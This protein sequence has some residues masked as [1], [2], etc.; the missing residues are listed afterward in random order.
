M[1]IFEVQSLGRS[2]GPGRVS[3]VAGEWPRPPIAGAIGRAREAGIRRYRPSVAHVSR[4]YLLQHVGRLDANPDH[5]R[6]RAHHCVWSVTGRRISSCQVSTRGPC[7]FISGV[8][9]RKRA[10]AALQIL[11]FATDDSENE[12]PRPTCK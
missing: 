9:E 3:R 6:N 11:E 1:T 7:S 2:T 10:E 5:A 8:L 4:R 12:S